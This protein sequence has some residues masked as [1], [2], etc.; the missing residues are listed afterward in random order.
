MNKKGM[1]NMLL[2]TITRGELKRNTSIE[3]LN[4]ALQEVINYNP[5]LSL[6]IYNS[7]NGL[8]IVD[9]RNKYIEIDI[10]KTL[11]KHTSYFRVVIDEENHY[12]TMYS[13]KY[14][15]TTTLYEWNGKDLY[16][17]SIDYYGTTCEKEKFNW[18][19]K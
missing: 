1:N 19:L 6:D 7:L 12:E 10:L 15:I 14:L 5:R 18:I 17:Q 11:T 8:I 13:S 16:K 4:N 9:L 2:L 3:D